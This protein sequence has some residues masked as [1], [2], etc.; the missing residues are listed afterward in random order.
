MRCQRTFDDFRNLGEFQRLEDEM[1][2]A[3]R[4]GVAAQFTHLFS[5]DL[6]QFMTKDDNCKYIKL[7][8]YE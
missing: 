8:T 2:E 5:S 3:A 1:A 4:F 7:S 6:S